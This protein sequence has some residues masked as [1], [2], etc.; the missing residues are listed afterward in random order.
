MTRLM[1]RCLSNLISDRE[2]LKKYKWLNYQ[3]EATEY[4]PPDYY[5]RLL[6]PYRFGGY[7]DVDLFRNFVAKSA[8]GS[9]FRALEI[10]PGPGRGTDVLLEKSLFSEIVLV[11]QSSRMLSFL[12]SK[13][14]HIESARYVATDAVEYLSNAR[15][16]Y[17]LIYSLW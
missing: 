1:C 10:G 4:L 5:L 17:E 7:S 12:E 13:L 3:Y 15:S 9:G 16:R 2:I 8:L 6:K 11:D 14:T